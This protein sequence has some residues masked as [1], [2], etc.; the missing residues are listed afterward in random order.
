MTPLTASCSWHLAFVTCH[1]PI[2]SWSL[3]IGH[4]LVLNSPLWLLALLAIPVVAML[5][6]RRRVAV[7]LVPFAAAWHRPSLASMSR[8]P[9]AL[10]SVGLVLLVARPRP[11]AKG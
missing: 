5:R 7:L 3:P 1:L 2:A 8:W 6:S 4:G 11:A 10:A 9:V